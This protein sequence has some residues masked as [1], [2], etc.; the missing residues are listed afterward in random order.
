[1]LS[2]APY[3]QLADHVRQTTALSQ[4]SGILMWDQEVMMPPKG[5]EAR[6]DQMAALEEVVHERRTDPRIGEWLAAL[7]GADLGAAEQANVR[8]ITR[9]YTRAIRV[10]PKLAAQI[11]RTTSAAQHAWAAA[12]QGSDF[13]AFAPHLSEVV[14]LRRE[15]AA[16]LAGGSGDADAL[17]DAL[18]DDY[19]PGMTVAQ[20]APL[21]EGMRPRLSALRAAI[22]ASGTPKL[23]LSG[24][25]DAEPQI[26]LARLIS[27]RVGYDFEAGRLDLSVHPFSSGTGGDARITTRVD[28]D[29]PMD[30]L[31][32]TIHELGHALYEQG[33]PQKHRLM[34]AGASVSMGVHESQSR[35]CENQI[36]RSRP[37]CTWLWPQIR[38]PSRRWWL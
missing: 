18:L 26:A 30:C 2:S 19:E 10:S 24:P 12:K 37:F 35:L 21:L 8:L 15:E 23:A 13:A 22:A 29:N 33:V 38:K 34:P 17:Y 28:A 14:T 3:E 4:A 25:F 31:Y 1:M 27:K 7:E 36:A 32:S 11:A 5:A 6:A 9:T 20:L 16:A